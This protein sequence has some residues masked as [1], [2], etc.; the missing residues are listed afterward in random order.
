M[1]TTHILKCNNIIEFAEKRLAEKVKRG[2]ILSYSTIDV[3]ANAI[4]VRKYL[5]QN[6]RP[7]IPTQTK[8]ERRFKN[9][10]I[11]R[12]EY[13]GIETKTYKLDDYTQIKKDNQPHTNKSYLLEI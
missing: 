7:K 6:P 10:E 9:L 12:K 13:S 1:N 11:K 3:I 2:D 4:K 5:D 8:E